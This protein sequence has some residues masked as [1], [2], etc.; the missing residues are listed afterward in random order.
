[1]DFESDLKLN[2]GF[3]PSPWW[4]LSLLASLLELGFLIR[5]LAIRLAGL[6]G[7]LQPKGWPTGGAHKYLALLAS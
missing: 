5:T 2:P 3:T 1:M 4:D 6:L 7:G